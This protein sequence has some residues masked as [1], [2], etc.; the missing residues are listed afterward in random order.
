MNDIQKRRWKLDSIQHPLPPSWKQTEISIEAARALRFKNLPPPPEEGDQAAT[1]VAF[2]KYKISSAVG[3]VVLCKNHRQG[4][5]YTPD[6]EDCLLQE[7]PGR[8]GVSSMFV[9]DSHPVN[10]P[11][12]SPCSSA[13]DEQN[14]TARPQSKDSHSQAQNVWSPSNVLA[15]RSEIS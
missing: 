5:M 4:Y 9:A 8:T 6:N 15:F 10:S 2:Q 7:L 11:Q 14:R 13:S 12:R 1:V 3:G